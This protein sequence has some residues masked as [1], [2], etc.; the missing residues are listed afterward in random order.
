[1]I[2][3]DI[4]PRRVRNS[5]RTG[6]RLIK[7][8][9]RWVT[10]YPPYVLLLISQTLS[11]DY[12]TGLDEYQLGN[13]K[14]AMYEWREVIAAPA[15]SIPPA[16]IA[17]TNYAIGMLYMLGQGVKKDYYKA[18]DWLEKAAEQNHGGAQG[19]LGYLYSQGLSVQRNYET[20]FEWFKKAAKQGDVDGQY[21]LGIFYL[22][23][24]GTEKDTTM[25]AQYLAAAS[26]HGDK[27]AE[28]ALQRLLGSGEV[29][30]GDPSGGE[31]EVVG[32]ETEDMDRSSASMSPQ[33]TVP[34]VH[35][36]HPTGVQGSFYASDW[37]LKQNPGFYTIQV[38][39]LRKISAIEDLIRDHENLAPYA[40]YTQQNQSKPLYVLIQGVYPDVESAREARDNFPAAIQNP[41]NVWIRKFGKIQNLITP[42]G[43]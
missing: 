37:I 7:A 33:H 40:V 27:D 25:A 32:M 34:P 17:E 5:L 15:G 30:D 3:D 1:L 42:S 10:S 14:T 2:K 28:I 23:G 35:N 8:N 18:R 36:V 13:Y 26:A 43:S 11:A 21:N 24:W 39:G 20:A 16:T 12:Q 38:I 6:Q 31:V 4:Y 41:K 19:K 9:I 29:I 22:N